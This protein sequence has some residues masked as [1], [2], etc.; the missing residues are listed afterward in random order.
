MRQERQF[1]VNWII[2]SG[3][4]L[5]RTL[6]SSRFPDLK[7]ISNLDNK[8]AKTKIPPEKELIC[9]YFIF[10][11]NTRSG[12]SWRRAKMPREGFTHANSSLSSTVGKER[13]RFEQPCQYSHQM[14]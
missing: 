5:R 9:F 8:H 13:A 4:L 10:V 7:P 1:A 12:G 14:I 2:R 11:K 3:Q 6:N